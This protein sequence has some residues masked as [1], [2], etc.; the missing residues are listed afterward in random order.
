MKRLLVAFV[1]LLFKYEEGKILHHLEM[2]EIN[3]FEDTGIVTAETGG[4]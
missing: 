2:T 3:G 1:F 4:S